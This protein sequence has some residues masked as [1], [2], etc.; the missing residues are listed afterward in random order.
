MNTQKKHDV[1]ISYSRKDSAIADEICSAFDEVGIT[2]FI[3]RRGMGGTANHVTKIANKIRNSKVMLLLA[4]ANSYKS[5][6]V[7]IEI[8]Y[9]FD[10]RVVVLPYA[11]DDTFP[12]EDF[13]ILL[14]RA[15]W[16]N[17]NND[18]IVPKLLTSIAELLGK[19]E[20]LVSKIEELTKK[21]KD[22]ELQDNNASKKSETTQSTTL[23]E[24][25]TQELLLNDHVRK[26]LPE[27]TVREIVKLVLSA[28]GIST[29]IQES[30]IRD[31]K[32]GLATAQNN[33]GYMLKDPEKKIKWLEKAAK[34]GSGAAMLTLGKLYAYGEGVEKN[35]NKAL[36]YFRAA[37]SNGY[38]DE[39]VS[40]VK[41]LLE[42][43][44][45]HANH[46]DLMS[47]TKIGDLYY[48]VIDK[49][50]T[51]LRV[52]PHKSYKD[53]HVIT[54]PDK[55]N[56][57]GI[58]FV[59]KEIDPYAFA[60]N[61]SLQ[62]INL[63]NS[64]EVIGNN[65]FEGCSSLSSI[66][67]PK[68]IQTIGDGAFK[69]C[70]SLKHLEIPS[71]LE[72]SAKKSLYDYY[73]RNGIYQPFDDL[74]STSI[75]DSAFDGCSSINSVILKANSIEE[76]C[77]ERGNNL[78]HQLGVLGKRTLKIN[79]VE[80]PHIIIPQGI[81]YL[82]QRAFYNFSSL[83]GV[84]IPETVEDIAKWAFDGCSSLAVIKYNGTKQQW[85]SI[86]KGVDWNKDIPAEVINCTDGDVKVDRIFRI[87]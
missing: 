69:F 44:G 85:A 65:A 36:D 63:P 16:H 79:G 22:L 21:I 28:D 73:L 4:S 49:H 19:E 59:V 81:K 52:V 55:I 76:F 29:E 31:L 34:N 57:L 5:D 84:T 68:S 14:I 6:Y 33:L 71:N 35:P 3:D 32:Y 67:L 61:N 74:T 77:K 37:S 86:N 41:E 10:Q 17:F 38:H 62:T 80:H 58:E 2:Y 24:I 83:E 53:I 23:E 12:P 39:A 11:L 78:L 18:P 8:H 70:S 46:E 60:N 30:F 45:D 82:G 1:F 47:G 48:E 7:S 64:L 26:S 66:A 13:K 15:N 56:C 87:Y 50:L 42:E 43:I 40:Y 54:I 20:E 9:A 72:S 25:V 27:T 75:G 51:N